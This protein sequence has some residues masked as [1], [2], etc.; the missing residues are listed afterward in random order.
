[1]EPVIPEVERARRICLD[2]SPFIYFIEAH[3]AFG[4]LVRPMMQ[5]ISRGEKEGVSSA[6]TLAELLVKPLQENRPDLA[7]QYRNA[8]VG[9]THFRLVAVEESVA[10]AAAL[11][12]ARYGFGL[13]DAIQLATAELEGAEVFVTNDRDLRRFSEVR[14]V[15]L[16]DYVARA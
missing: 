2:A 14:V 10:E 1:M 11:I 9:Q 5:S 6:V 13:P 4:S 8:L 7:R 3:P 15:V 12:K 16:E